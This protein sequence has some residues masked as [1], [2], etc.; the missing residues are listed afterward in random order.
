MLSIF[1]N[2]PRELPWYGSQIGAKI[3]RNC[4]HFSSVQEIQTFSCK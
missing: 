1:S 3:S 4:T 2:E